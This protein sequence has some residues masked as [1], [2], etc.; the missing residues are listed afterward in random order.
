[1]T[2]NDEYWKFIMKHE[3]KAWKWYDLSKNKNITCDIVKEN[4]DKPWN[5]NGL[6]RNE[7]IT[8]DFVK[9]N[10]DKPWDL[11]G[12]S[13][14][15]FNYDKELFYKRKFVQENLLEEFVKYYMRPKR[16]INILETMNIEPVQL[17]EYL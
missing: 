11:G 3:N 15:T 10:P 1:M 4:L 9:D 8:W 14:N 7:N 5:W 6:S 13:Y 2:W 17:D 12:L 16:I